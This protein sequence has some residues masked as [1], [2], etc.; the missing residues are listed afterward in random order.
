MEGRK[1]KL[2]LPKAVVASTDESAENPYLFMEKTRWWQ[3]LKNLFLLLQKTG[4]TVVALSLSQTHLCFGYMCNKSSA[5]IVC[6]SVQKVFVL[7]NGS[8]LSCAATFCQ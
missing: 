1:K 3:L 6:P 2:S 8:I 4:V 5:D 7:S